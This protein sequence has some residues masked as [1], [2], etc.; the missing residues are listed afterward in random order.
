VPSLEPRL[1]PFWSTRLLHQ[2]PLFFLGPFEEAST[3]SLLFP[4]VDVM[5]VTSATHEAAYESGR[6]FTI[7]MQAGRITRLAGSRMPCT[8]RDELRALT[9][10]ADDAFHRR[11]VVATYAHAGGWPGLVPASAAAAMPET[12]RRLRGGEPIAI[13]VT[14]DSISEGYNASAFIQSPPFQPAYPSLAAS[15]SPRCTARR[16]ICRTSR[17][18]G[19]PPMTASQ[20][21]SD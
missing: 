5:S 13:A 4:P 7:D 19:G 10:A 20:M 21:R 6:D 8:R 17:S 3:A 16:S 12:F 9:C 18:Q 14:G 11:Q 1:S 2:E 15:G